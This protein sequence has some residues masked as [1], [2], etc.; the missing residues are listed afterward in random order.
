M[1]KYGRFVLSAVNCD[2]GS[3]INAFYDCIVSIR[4]PLA[5]RLDRVKQR[6]FD[7]FGSRILK[8]GDMYEQEQRFFDFVATRTMDKTDAWLQHAKC[9]VIYIDGTEPVESNARMIQERLSQ[10]RYN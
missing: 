8:G 10:I 3:E 7:E 4:V 2:F 6:S 5:V 9:P 1:K